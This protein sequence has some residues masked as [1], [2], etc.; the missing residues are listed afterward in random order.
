MTAR[1]ILMQLAENNL[2]HTDRLGSTRY[3]GG[4]MESSL[5]GIDR[6]LSEVGEVFCGCNHEWRLSA[7]HT[8]DMLENELFSISEPRWG[9]EE[10]SMR[11]KNL[12]CRLHRFYSTKSC[13]CQ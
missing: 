13:C 11:L 5:E 8:T 12:R 6:D 3:F 1:T 2:L 9:S 7:E 10:Q 4:A